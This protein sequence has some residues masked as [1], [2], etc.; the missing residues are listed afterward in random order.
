[1]L[2]ICIPVPGSTGSTAPVLGSLGRWWLQLLWRRQPNLQRHPGSHLERVKARELR[3]AV[4]MA[5]V[6]LEP[7]QR[8]LS[9]ASWYE[10]AVPAVPIVPAAA[11][12]AAVAAAATTATFAA[13]A[14]AAA[15]TAAAVVPAVTTTASTVFSRFLPLAALEVYR[16]P[17]TVCTCMTA[18]ATQ[19]SVRVVLC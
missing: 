5:V 8:Q 17:V 13:A 11:T 16:H 14:V 4:W 3:Q 10:S 9:W 18:N 2:V 15:T 6:R 12:T 7:L 1:M 19:V